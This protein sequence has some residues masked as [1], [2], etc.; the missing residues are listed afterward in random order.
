MSDPL[1]VTASIIAVLQLANTATQYIK[2]IKHGSSDRMRLRDELR[3][4]VCLLEMLQDR[5]ED[6]DSTH[7]TGEGLK[8]TSIT[9]LA[10][11]DGPVNTFKRVLEE[12]VAKLAPQ[13]RLRQLSRHF[14]WPFD[15][16][17][18]VDML[19]SLERLKSHF[20]LVMQNDLVE[21][22][23]LSNLKI[24]NLGQKM[25]NLDARSQGRETQKII[26]WVSPISFRARQIDTLESVQPGTG[27]WFLQHQTF[28]SWMNGDIEM[29]WCP[30]IPGAGKTRLM[31]LVIDHFERQIPSPSTKCTYIYC[32]YGRR[33]E[34]THTILLAALLQQ[35]LQDSAG[36]TLLAEASSLYEMHKKYGTRP[37]LAQVTDVFRKAVAQF[38]GFYVIIDALDECAETD[39]DAIQFVSILRSIDPSIKLL[40]TSRFSTSFERYFSGSKRLDISAQGEDIRIY[41]D[42]Q[43]AQQHRLKRHVHA[44]PRLKDEI[45]ETIIGESQGMFLLAKLHVESLSTKINRKEVRRSLK[46]LPPTLDA[47]YLNALERIYS[48]SSVD[49]S[50]AES[51]LFWVICARRPLGILEIQHMYATQELPE[52]EGLEEDDLPD[53]EILTSV[54]GGLI[55]IDGESQTARAVHYTAHQ[56]LERTQV[57]NI[58]KARLSLTRI[59]LKYLTLPNFSGGVCTTDKSMSDRLEQYPFLDYAARYWGSE[60]SQLDEELPLLDFRKFTSNATCVEITNQ[61]W[62]VSGAHYLNWSQEFPRRVPAFVLASAFKLPRTIRQMVLDGHEIESKGTDCE[63][64]LI[65]A[66]AFGQ[67]E[68]VRVLV[69]LG[70]AV[71]AR[72]YKDETALFKAAKNGKG[73]IVRILLDGG[74]DVHTKAPSDWTALMSAVSG[75][76][77][78]VARMLAE[79]GADL[80][81]ETTWG[82]SALS[83][84]ARTGQEAIAIY[85]ADSGVTLPNGPAGRRAAVAASRRGLQQ[86]ANRLTA[87]YDAI[88]HRPLPRQS[89]RIMDGLP[90]IEE[91]AHRAVSTRV[92]N[93][94]SNDDFS[95]LM[96]SL[97]YKIG[98]S[99][100]YSLGKSLGKGHFAEVFVCSNRVTNVSEPG[101]SG[102]TATLCGTP[103]YVA[104]E[105]LKSASHRRYG[106]A[107]DIWSAGVVLY[108]CL[109]GF[110]PFSDELYTPENPYT[111]AQQIKMGR[112]DYPSPYWDPVG[113]PALDLIDRMILVDVDKRLKAKEC[114][115]HPWM[116]GVLPVN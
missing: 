37:T 99:K 77:F 78:D 112:F 52:D 60:A 104:P 50:L 81:A 68:N 8:A 16:K 54:C 79:A 48:Q 103:S 82:D 76:H 3:G 9:A 108:I 84:A 15:K 83:I 115:A 30:G 35:V 43:I 59:S 63:T 41:L 80:M 106:S 64:A 71:N 51:V 39:E 88:A 101:A 26:D 85:L 22:G 24:D 40:C 62:S 46:I 58:A 4:T 36:D 33:K 34:Q 25:E 53:K 66:A 67:T 18:I 10:G 93:D 72:D 44:D 114:L 65:R 6:S 90:E 73:N 98:F 89:S 96:Q 110:P 69:D 94:T 5:I 95:E 21:L 57:Q 107:V 105:I 61:V 42:Q 12:I 111:L 13:D 27:M 113:D 19:G 91:T 29:L 49:I 31:S 11:S 100:T 116:T 23:K 38:N 32:D 109:C 1:S 87:D 45:I 56:Y 55:L 75:G 92:Q 47:T 7:D 20:N 102:Y 28:R 97:G 2:D 74:A 14:S 17:E 86:L 70:A